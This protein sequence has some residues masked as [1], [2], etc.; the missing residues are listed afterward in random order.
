MDA[1]KNMHVMI[2]KNK[3]LHQKGLNLIINADH[4]PQEGHQSAE[5]A[6][7]VTIVQKIFAMIIESIGL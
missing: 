1:N 6:V 3:I 7:V 4:S 5:H 2:N